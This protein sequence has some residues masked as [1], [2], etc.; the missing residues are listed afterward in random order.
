MFLHVFKFSKCMICKIPKFI[1]PNINTIPWFTPKM[2]PCYLET[3]FFLEEAWLLS[4]S[5]YFFAK[6]FF[7]FLAV[8]NGMSASFYLSA[9]IQGKTCAYNIGD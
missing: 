1:Q 8:S 5:K 9:C 2:L 3:T 7:S 6:R 4:L